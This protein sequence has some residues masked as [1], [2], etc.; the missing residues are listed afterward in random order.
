MDWTELSRRARQCR[1]GWSEHNNHCYKLMNEKVSFSTANQRCKG[2][3]ANLASILEGQENNFIANASCDEV[4]IGLQHNMWT[5]G[6][7]FPYKNWAKGQPNN[8]W[9]KGGEKCVVIYTK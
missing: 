7:A 6:S 2:M 3:G 9:I 1:Y 5:D 8:H 4:W